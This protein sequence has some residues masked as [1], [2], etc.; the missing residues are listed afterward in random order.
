M[1]DKTAIEPPPPLASGGNVSSASFASK[2][3]LHRFRRFMNKPVPMSHA[4]SFQRFLLV[5]IAII[6]ISTIIGPFARQAFRPSE[7]DVLKT[8]SAT[9]V[10][11]SNDTPARF[12]ADVDA[13]PKDN[14]FTLAGGYTVSNAAKKW[15]VGDTYDS[16]KLSTGAG[17]AKAFQL[18]YVG[19]G[20]MVYSCSTVTKSCLT[21]FGTDSYQDIKIVKWKILFQV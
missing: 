6:A 3:P 4:K 13:L 2:S 19:P 5:C 14:L 21:N 18:S 20:A 15:V 16:A 10:K 8:M 11:L 17:N 1:T 9:Y 7:A 12:K